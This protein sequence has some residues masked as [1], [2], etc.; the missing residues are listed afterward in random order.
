V[1]GTEDFFEPVY[2]KGRRTRVGTELTFTP[3]PVGIEAEWMRAWEQRKGQGLGDTDLSDLIT[4]GYYASV[5]WLLTG[6]EKADFNRPRRSLFAGGP[7]AIEAA[8]RYETLG[9]ESAEKV[10]PPFRNP[11]AEHIFE[12]SDI[13]WT[14][15]VN[16]FLN[17]WVRITGNGIREEFEDARRTPVPGTTVFWSGVGRLQ[18]V[19]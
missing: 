2:V 11:R 15:G 4:T 5:S 17:R 7:G 9:F 18:I 6:E 8:V 14:L 19:F 12:N 3:G 10:G 16:W 13:V 1:Y